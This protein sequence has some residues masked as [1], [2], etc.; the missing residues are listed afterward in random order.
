MKNNKF[1]QL[2]EKHTQHIVWTLLCLMPII[3]MAVD[4][5]APSLPAIANGLHV[6]NHAAKNAISIY[7]LGYALGNFLTGFLTD[8]LGR[9]KLIRLSLL[10]F[11]GVS[12][13]PIFLPH[14]S[15]LLL[16]RLLQGLTIGAVAVLARAILSDILPPDK[17]IRL[18]TLIGTMWGLGPVLGPIFG[19]YLQSYFGWKAGFCA[20]AFLAE[21]GFIATYLIVPETHINRHPLKVKTIQKNLTEVLTN[22]LFLALIILM[23]FAYS[24]IIVF[25]TMGP[26]L[27]QA[28]LNYSP[29]FFGHFALCLW[30][31]F[32]ASTFVCRIFL[33]QYKVEDQFSVIINASLFIILA[34]FCVSLFF[35]NSI[36]LT[37]V[38]SGLMFFTCGFIFPLSMGKGLSLFRHIAGTAT[39]TMYLVNILIT[40]QSAF[41]VSFI[42]IQNLI[43]LLYVYLFLLLGCV[44]IYFGMIRNYSNKYK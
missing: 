6:S 12:L 43:P 35:R 29:I 24:L 4:L 7:L 15:F 19:G 26:F 13:L 5:I 21:I 38:P 41:L 17:L 23:G 10:G 40:C 44:L 32:V 34:L 3:G 36:I 28:K 37:A 25:N 30:L 27:I 1:S 9:Q 14:I 39:A 16:A 20:F 11:M 18:G 31:V 22:R 33:K 2:T 8:A 42:N